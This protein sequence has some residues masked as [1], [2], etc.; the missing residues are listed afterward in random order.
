MLYS[1]SS[2]NVNKD[3]VRKEKDLFQ[4]Y[5]TK[6]LDVWFGLWLSAK[7][8]NLSSREFVA[9]T[10][11]ICLFPDENN[12]VKTCNRKETSTNCV[13]PITAK[14]HLDYCRS[15]IPGSG[16]AFSAKIQISQCRVKPYVWPVSN[17]RVNL[18][19]RHG[20]YFTNFSE[21]N[22]VKYLQIDPTINN[23]EQHTHLAFT[24]NHYPSWMLQIV[25][26]CSFFRTVSP[27]MLLYY[28]SVPRQN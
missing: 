14:W 8:L 12:S 9:N 7:E 16:H 1:L 19:F 13:L 26:N 17:F 22:W 5:D 11:F 27:S 20:H 15:R 24:I 18:G 21:L 4:V 2:F 3:F 10:W 6:I 23:F 25:L 28:L